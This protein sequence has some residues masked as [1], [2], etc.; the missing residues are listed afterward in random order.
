MDVHTIQIRREEVERELARLN[1]RVSSLSTELEELIIAEKVLERLSGAKRNSSSS[2]N[3]RHAPQAAKKAKG[4]LPTVREMI[5]EALMDASQRNV[6]GL[7]P[8]E[9][10]QYIKNVHGVEIK[11]QI[12]TTASRMYH[13]L[14]EI[15]KNEEKGI[16]MIPVNKKPADDTTVESPSTGYLDN[17]LAKGR[18]AVPGGGA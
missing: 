15:G 3:E 17:L 16:F 4:K 10:R 14:K 13:D 18:E 1:E 9:I 8:N 7:T 2:A 5:K 11:Q 6:E 12:N